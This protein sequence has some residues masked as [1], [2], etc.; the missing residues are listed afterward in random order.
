[1]NRKILKIVISGI[2]VGIT[3]GLLISLFFSYVYG[4]ENYFPSAPRFIE[5]FERPLNALAISIVLW[6]L[7]GI[8]FSVSS[9][10]F[11]KENWSITRQTITH[12]LVTFGGFTPLAILSG[13]FPLQWGVFIFFTI[14]F[15]IIYII[16]WLVSMTSARRDIEKIN[17]NLKKRSS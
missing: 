14:I 4:L 5:R 1:M 8:L 3:I 6:A 17:R 10:I 2:P 9:L 16:M 11:E 13:W 7:I 12:F 15:I